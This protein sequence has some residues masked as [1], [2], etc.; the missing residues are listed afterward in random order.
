MLSMEQPDQAPMDAGTYRIGE[1]LKA[2][3]THGYLQKA[4]E[5][6]DEVIAIV[7]TEVTD[8]RT[9]LVRACSAGE[10]L[11]VWRLGIQKTVKVRSITGV[12]W[13][14][15]DM[16]YQDATDGQISKTASTSRPI[17]HYPEYGFADKTTVEQIT[18]RGVLVYVTLDVAIGTT[19]V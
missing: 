4:T 13:A 1:T 3:S 14:A 10:R 6:G 2:S 19:N 5:K 7:A 9:G 18:G 11:G 16:A 12:S 8:P 15:G 17:G